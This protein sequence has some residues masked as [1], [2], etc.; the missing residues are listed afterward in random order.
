M[1]TEAIFYEFGQNILPL[2]W[3]SR[4]LWFPSARD[5]RQLTRL[6]VSRLGIIK[7]TILADDGTLSRTSFRLGRLGG[8]GPGH[9]YQAQ[10]DTNRAW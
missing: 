10:P 9:R 5:P 4:G 3:N 2:P 1:P 8:P 7:M 6:L